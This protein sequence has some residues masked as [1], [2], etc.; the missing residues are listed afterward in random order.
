MEWLTL[1][2]LILAGIALVVIEI[3]FIPGTTIIGIIGVSLLVFGIIFGYGKF[4]STTGTIILVSTLA[5]GGAATFISFRSGLWRTFALKNTNQSKF[6]ED[7]EIKHLLGAEGK[8]ISALRP[9]GKAEFYNK[10]YE[11][12]SQGFYANAGSRLK[13][14][15]V[16][17]NKT[18]YVEL[19][20]E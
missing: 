6:N 2:L 20:K 19:I 3:I 17:N 4:G 18:V 8:A 16:D 1:V 14:I 13:V 9:Y 7:M 5:L 10:I 12:K 11:V 15:K